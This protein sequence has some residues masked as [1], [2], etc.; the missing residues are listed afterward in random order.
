MM[1]AYQPTPGVGHPGLPHGHPG[2]APTPGH[3]GQTMQMHPGVSGAPHVSQPGAMMGM[4]PGAQGMGPGGMGGQHPNGMMQAQMGGHSVAGGMP[5]Q[6]NMSHMTPQQAMQQQVMMQQSKSPI[7][8]L[9]RRRQ[10]PLPRPSHLIGFET[11]LSK[12][13]TLLTCIWQC[14]TIHNCCSSS[15]CSVCAIISSNRC[16]NSKLPLSKTA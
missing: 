16:S 5:G 15:K 1:A 6:Q 10:R 8:M 14:K 4:Q 13:V 12:F 7:H 11:S 9:Q 3:M 2:M